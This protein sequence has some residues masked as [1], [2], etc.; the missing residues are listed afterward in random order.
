MPVRSLV[1]T[2]ILLA[3]SLALPAQEPV[4]PPLNPRI[5]TATR[6]VTLFSGLE[7]QLLQ[8]VQKKD[9]AALQAMLTDEFQ[10]EMP[11]ADPMAGED[12][13]DS[14]MAKDFTLKSSAIREVSVVDLGNA[15]VVKFERRQDAVYKG[16]AA[17]GEFFVVDLWKK[18]GDTW[19]L[20]NRYVSRSSAVS[21]APK[22]PVRPT[23]KQ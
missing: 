10:V 11:N 19:K 21:A 2:A 6:Q 12:W 15:A 16:S 5:I 18:D 20:A 8:A 17:G 7:R 14:V 13:L 23:G 22:R 3:A 9:K 4:K 1:F